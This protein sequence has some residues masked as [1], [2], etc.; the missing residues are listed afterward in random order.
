[1]KSSKRF[2]I[3]DCVWIPDAAEVWAAG[4]VESEAA[5]LDGFLLG[6]RKEDNSIVKVPSHN[7]VARNVP[8]SDCS[9]DL[10]A[11]QCLDE[12]NVLHG[13]TERFKRG[14]IYTRA[15]PCVLIALNPWQTI[16][17]YGSDQV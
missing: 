6:V 3:D 11:L 13:V 10:A 9:D 1:M 7:V 14:V 12:A 15:T 8:G 2:H 17:L 5:E 16:S 4:V